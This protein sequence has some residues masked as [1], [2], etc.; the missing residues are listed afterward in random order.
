[1]KTLI[2]LIL[3]LIGFTVIIFSC[4]DDEITNDCEGI[5]EGLFLDTRDGKTY[6]TVKIGNQLWMAENLNYDAGSG[7]WVYDDSLSNAEVYG[8]LYDWE[9]ALD[10]CPDCW[11]LP[12]DEDW[13]T[14]IHYLGENVGGKMRTT[15]TI[16]WDSPNEGATNSSGFSALPGGLRC[17]GGC[18]YF[19][20]G[21]WGTFWSSTNI[22]TTY[23]WRVTLHENNEIER[24]YGDKLVAKSV[25]C[26]RD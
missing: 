1:M 21:L 4:N 26:L 5:S 8:R 16:Y 9:I 7:S 11:H 25:R 15:D 3:I 19:G 18:T 6:K 23:A 17:N 22:D 13:Q 2:F 12:S 24:T 20:K 14:L 10:A